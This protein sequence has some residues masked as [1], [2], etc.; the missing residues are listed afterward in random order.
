MAKR[1]PER[2]REGSVVT[3]V[4]RGGRERE[5]RPEEEGAAAGD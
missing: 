4:C 3:V 2:R 5:G 1:R